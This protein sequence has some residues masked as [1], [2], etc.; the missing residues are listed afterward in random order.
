MIAPLKRLKTL[1]QQNS[2]YFILLILT[3]LYLCI[4]LF[5][6]PNESKY[7]IDESEFILTIENIRYK[8]D[9]V[10][11]EFSGQ[12][13]LISYYK[14]DFPYSLGDKVKVIGTLKEANNNTI[15]NLFNYKKYLY[16]NDIHYIL[17]INEIIPL[18]KNNNLI[19]KIKN[20]LINRIENI[21]LNKEYLYAFILGETY[22]IDSDIKDNYQFN[23]VSH[24]LAI[25]SSSITIITC[26]VTYLFH[27]FKINDYLYLLFMII[28]VFIYIVLTNYSVSIIRCGLAFI[29]T[30]INKKLKLNIKYQN[31]LI[32]ITSISLFYNPYYVYNLG[33][34]YSYLISFVLVI[35]NDLIT[36][37]YLVKLLKVSMIAYLVSIPINIYNNFEVNFFSIILNLLYVPLVNFI[38]F[39]L[40]LIVL[41][42]PFLNGLLS[43]VINFTESIT[44]LFS[45]VTFFSIVLA[46]P[47]LFIVIVY[48]IVIFLFLY[49]WRHKMYYLYLPF[50]IIMFIHFN[51]NH[52]IKEDF[53]MMVDVKQ[54]DCILL[55]SNDKV[56]LI[57]TGGSYNYEYSDNIVSYL[58]SIG[59]NK[60]DYLFITHGDMDH[61]GSSYSLV[62]KIRLDR[63]Y[64]NSN[65]YNENE[66]RLIKQLKKKNIYY[67]KISNE[68]FKINNFSIKAISYDLGNENDSSL[69]LLVK[70]KLKFLLMGDAS[71]K[72][73]DK[74]LNE[75]NLSN[76]DILKLGHHGSYTSTGER[77]IRKIKPN[78]GLISVGKNNLYKH[79]S[80]VVLD[81]LENTNIY[82]TDYDGSVLLK[83]KNNKLQIETYAP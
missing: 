22:Y 3:T 61:I 8:E 9:K 29:L 2:F 28:L 53:V 54:G 82:R 12:E 35:Y 26:L 81:R 19:F 30:Y 5:L 27:K 23:G 44:S 83:I 41:F 73:E 33:F 57:D 79:P 62:E 71:I 17:D 49:G 68:N 48:Y 46:K 63:V 75:Y 59:I 16:N 60:I 40:S 18:Q 7:Q 39:P 77:L 55:K 20:F 4:N 80:K 72:S 43:I 66:L 78:I 42:F 45:N 50:V 69:M 64:F 24:L 11:I 67:Q 37:N 74:L 21:S 58:K 31:L 36:G 70:N 51:I 65:D 47:N 76:F 32:L 13:N 15:P 52:I 38:I 1:L 25:G 14:D 34:Q 6:I 56:V 10:T